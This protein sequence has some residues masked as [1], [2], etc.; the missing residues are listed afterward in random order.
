MIGVKVGGWHSDPCRARWG[1]FLPDLTRLASGSSTT[2]LPSNISS[3]STKKASQEAKKMKINSTK[4]SFKLHSQLEN[5]TKLVAKLAL[6]DVLLMNDT[7]WPWLILVPRIHGAEEIHHLTI[8]D[9]HEMLA[10][11]NEVALALEAITACEKVNIA[12]IGNIVRQLHIHIIAR[13][14]NDPNWPKPVWG[15][16]SSIAYDDEEADK[17]I[18]N[19]QQRLDAVL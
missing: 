14:Q 8:D 19:L 7:R 9:Q 1:C 4:Q 17:L 6:C 11:I 16:E 18:K 2:N 10:E 3:I 5:D 13:N 12:A 15:F